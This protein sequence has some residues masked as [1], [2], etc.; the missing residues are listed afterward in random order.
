MGVTGGTYLEDGRFAF[1][2]HSNY[3]KEDV[4]EIREFA[5][6]YHLTSLAETAER[7]NSLPSVNGIPRQADAFWLRDGSGALLTQADGTEQRKI[8]YAPTNGEFL[9]GLTLVFGQNPHAFQWQPEI[10]MP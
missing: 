6:I 3:S 5:G 7:V 9:Y 2:L 1:T 10:I 4:A 8:Y